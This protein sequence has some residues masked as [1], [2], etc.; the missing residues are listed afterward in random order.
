MTYKS[1]AAEVTFTNNG[2]AVGYVNTFTIVGNAVTFFEPVESIKEITAGK[3]KTIRVDMP[4]QENE[5]FALAANNMIENVYANSIQMNRLRYSVN[6]N[7]T[8]ISTFFTCDIGNRVAITESVTGLSATEGFINQV[9]WS[10]KPG[11]IL[12]CTYL[13]APARDTSD[14]CIVGTST[15]GSGVVYFS[16]G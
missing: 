5:S 12:D 9:E 4:Y 13:L 11:S 14:R 16:G 2:N 6:L 1:A 3:H 10:L 8:S 7:T 15:V